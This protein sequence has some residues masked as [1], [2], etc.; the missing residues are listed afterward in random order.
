MQTTFQTAYS[1]WQQAYAAVNTSSDQTIE[2][3]KKLDG[4]EVS[5][6]ITMLMTPVQSAVDRAAKLETYI[7]R[8]VAG[9][10]MPK[11]AAIKAQIIAEAANGTIH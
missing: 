11:A 7:K 2:Q 1:A 3:E 9:W 4:D 5:A 8:E 10:N 6:L